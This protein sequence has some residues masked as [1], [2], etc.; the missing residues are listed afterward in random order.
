MDKTYAQL[1]NAQFG[2]RLSSVRRARRVSQAELGRRIGFSRA[3]VAN[4]ESGGQNVQL[5]QVYSI[6][7]AL[8]TPIDDLL[9]RASDLPDSFAPARDPD[10]MFLESVKRQLTNM[11]GERK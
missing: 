1:V 4:L 5:H 2:E 7:R 8:D 11:F 6:A 10:V 3:T 9:P